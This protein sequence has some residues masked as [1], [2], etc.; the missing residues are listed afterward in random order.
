MVWV[1]SPHWADLCKRPLG[2]NPVF[3]LATQSLIV[4]YLLSYVPFIPY[5]AT[6]AVFLFFW[7]IAVLKITL[8]KMSLAHSFVLKLVLSRFRACI[9][10]EIFPLCCL[11]QYYFH[12][13]YAKNFGIGWTVEDPPVGEQI[14][15]NIL[16]IHCCSSDSAS[17]GCIL[18][19]RTQQH[20]RR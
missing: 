10:T 9:Q 2:K 13:W 20:L 17:D 14:W 11:S 3:P 12:Y 18:W 19:I 7:K 15:T 8:N 5:G 1:F 16:D 6:L 4:G